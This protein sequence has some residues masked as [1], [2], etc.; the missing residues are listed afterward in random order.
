MAEQEIQ[1]K[2][3]GKF[4]R[5]LKWIGVGC[6]ALLVLAAVVLARL[7]LRS[8]LTLQSAEQ[9]LAAIEAARAIPDEENAAT[10]YERLMKD[11]GRSE[12]PWG[13]VNINTD[14]TPDK[15]WLSDDN[16]QLATWIEGQQPL[17]AGLL[18][19][20]T[21]KQ[22]RFPITGYPEKQSLRQTQQ[23]AMITWAFLLLRA[24][25]N[26]VAEGRIESGAEKY[27]SVIAM[28][29]HFAQQPVIVDNIVGLAVE[30]WPLS[31]MRPFIV[32]GPF[33]QQHLEAIQAA[34]PPIDNKW[35]N[36]S[37]QIRKVDRLYQRKEDADWLAWIRSFWQDIPAPDLERLHEL[38]LGRLSS[39]RVTLI[40][41]ALRRCKDRT[42]QWPQSL[43]QIQGSLPAEALLDP[44]NGEAF[45]YRLTEDGFTL[46]SKGQ[47]SIDEQGEFGARKKGRPDDLPYWPPWSRTI[48]QR[49]AAE[50]Q[51]AKPD[52]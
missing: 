18:E 2:K 39:R 30:S 32:E 27:L 26:D 50:K 29:G 4:R 48:Q 51:S 44:V 28:G 40:L 25:N 37:P 21:K 14:T 8:R 42:G 12:V 36:F 5:L 9:Q 33:Q 34:L 47:N 23:N 46:Y 35:D 20:S 15:P 3:P 1:K 38:Y 19:A 45:V 52:G 7:W 10:I 43:D 11:Y 16:P 6:R 13:V 41:I 24:G 17:I 49:K 31:R 22:C